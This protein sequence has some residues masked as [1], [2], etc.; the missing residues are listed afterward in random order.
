VESRIQERLEELRAQ[1][2]RYRAKATTLHARLIELEPHNAEVATLR[3]TLIESSARLED[4][5]RQLLRRVADQ[6]DEVP[7]GVVDERGEVARV[8]VR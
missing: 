3:R 6:L 1:I 8:D 2:A 4:V 5:V 7:V